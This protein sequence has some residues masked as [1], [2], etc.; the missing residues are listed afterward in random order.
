[1]KYHHHQ[2]FTSY[3]TTLLLSI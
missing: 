3:T 2:S 1:M